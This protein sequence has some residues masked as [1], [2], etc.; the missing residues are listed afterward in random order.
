MRTRWEKDKRPTKIDARTFEEMI[1]DLDRAREKK[2]LE[3][4]LKLWREGDYSVKQRR[5]EA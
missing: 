1:R 3:A 5:L 2:M 4:W